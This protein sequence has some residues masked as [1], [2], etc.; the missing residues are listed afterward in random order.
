[1][2]VN[3]LISKEAL[4]KKSPQE[5]TA[6]LY[7]A[8]LNNLEDAKQA[9]DEKN[10]F[11]ANEKLQKTNDIFQRLGAGINYEA[12]IIADQLDALYNYLADRLVTANFKKDTTIIDEVITT[13]DSLSE[14]WAKALKS[15]DDPSQKTLK[16]KNSAY[17]QNI[18]Y[19]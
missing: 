9:I 14:A 16:M 3:E 1:M 2:E 7:E 4:H 10:Y 12:G 15:N 19:E 11:V 5:I 13:I 6:L 18:K 17:E 8:C